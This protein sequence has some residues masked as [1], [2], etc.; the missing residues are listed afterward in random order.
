MF[1]TFRKL[2]KCL[3]RYVRLPVVSQCVWASGIK[4]LAC[5]IT[6][7]NFVLSVVTRTKA[8]HKWSLSRWKYLTTEACQGSALTN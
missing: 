2:L 8:L 5:K 7:N 6:C 4:N 1:G 3:C